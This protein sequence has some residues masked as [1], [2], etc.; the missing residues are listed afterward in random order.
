MLELSSAERNAPYRKLFELLN[1]PSRSI[2]KFICRLSTIE[3]YPGLRSVALL[4]TAFFG[5]TYLCEA[6]FSQM[7]IIKSRYG[8]RLNVERLKYCL[9]LCL[10]NFE[11]SFSKLSQTMQCHA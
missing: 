3:Q 7:K 5:S 4:L 2:P 10:S 9:Y 8:S 6:A 11:P 1:N